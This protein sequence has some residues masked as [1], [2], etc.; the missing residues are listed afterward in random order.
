VI[1]SNLGSVAIADARLDEQDPVLA[2]VRSH[3]KPE[4]STGSTTW[5]SSTR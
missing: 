1:T 5:W 2:A 4:F 3:F